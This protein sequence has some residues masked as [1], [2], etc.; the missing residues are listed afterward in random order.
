MVTNGRYFLPNAGDWQCETPSNRARRKAKRARRGK[1]GH[2]ATGRR[3]SS[4]WTMRLASKRHK[5]KKS[6]T[7]PVR[8]SRNVPLLTNGFRSGKRAD[9]FKRHG[10][11]LSAT[12]AI[13]YEAMADVF[14]G[15]PRG[16]R[17]ECT[18]MTNGDI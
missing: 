16:R 11:S 12:T 6:K 18:R 3:S 7:G 5:G 13:H 14:L 9:H 8:R 10:K 2:Q 4:Y 15:G 17:L 1:T